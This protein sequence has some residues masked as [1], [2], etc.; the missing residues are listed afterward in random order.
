[1]SDVNNE[2][3]SIESSLSFQPN[4]FA[5]TGFRWGRF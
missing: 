5:G 3:S 1:V 2:Q 4:G